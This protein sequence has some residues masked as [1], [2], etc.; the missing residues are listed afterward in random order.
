MMKEIK[1]KFASGFLFLDLC[2]RNKYL[3]P[4]ENNTGA[5]HRVEICYRKQ[6]LFLFLVS[7]N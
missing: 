5:E 2:S 1:T 7:P 3:H 4:V 6:D